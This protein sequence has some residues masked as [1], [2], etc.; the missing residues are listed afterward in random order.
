MRC[1]Y[2]MTSS[3]HNMTTIKTFSIL[4]LLSLFTYAHAEPPAIVAHRGASKAAP[5]N[6]IPAFKLA[7][8]KQ[9][10]AIEA[11]FLLTKDNHIVCIHDKS[12]NKVANKSLIINESSLAELRT[13][14]VGIKHNEK[15]KG[16]VIPLI[17][18]VFATVPKQKKI[19]IEIKSGIEI[20]PHLIKEIDKSG[21][22]DEQ[23][24]I[25][26]FNPIILQTIKMQAP[27]YKTLWL[28]KI[29]K[30]FGRISPSTESILSTLKTI[31][32]DGVST[33]KEYISEITVKKV[34]QNGHEYHAWTVDDAA[35]AT[36]LSKWGV[37]S[38]TTNVPAEIKKQFTVQDAK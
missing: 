11:D 35:T 4:L 1:A 27:Q 33:N 18:E 25:I 23:I 16:T 12:T 21:L 38:I 5:E 19:Y 36:K 31:N 17:S 2:P 8:L 9:A 32:A 28:C 22:K 26:C 7:W 37:K 29:K 24:V 6:T 15:F 10:D 30:R 14:D 20:I 3:P 34:I 13:I